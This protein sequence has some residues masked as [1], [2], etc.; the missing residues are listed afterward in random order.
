MNWPMKNTLTAIMPKATGQRVINRKALPLLPRPSA[1]K[2]GRLISSQTAASAATGTTQK[3]APRQ[4]ISEPRK[5]PAGA[6][7]TVASAFP[8]LT[9]A[10][11]RDTC[12]GGTRRMAV[13]AD[14]DQKPPMAMPIKARPNMN[15]G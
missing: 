14:N 1:L 11:A 10:S 6:A 9:M 7:M 4:P 13:A 12:S 15:D 3:N 5:L 8:P 2:D